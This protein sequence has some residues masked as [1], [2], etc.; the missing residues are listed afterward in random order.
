MQR[1][2]LLGILV[3]CV[4]GAPLAAF[5]QG[6]TGNWELMVA[7]PQGSNPMTMTLTQTGTAV[8]GTMT[9]PFGS[10]PMTGTVSGTDVTLAAE[11]NLQGRALPLTFKGTLQGDTFN[12]SL[13]IAGMGE[14]AFTGK[15]AAAGASGIAPTVPSAA[16]SAPASA[17]PTGAG[18]GVVSP[19]YVSIPLEIS[20]SK[21]AADVWKR[22]GK[23]CDVGEWLQVPCT[24][25]YGKD[26]ELGAI[27]SVA[28]EILVGKTD[29]SYTYTQP[30]RDGQRY[31]HYHGTLEA[32]PLT[33]TTSK[34]VYTL[35]FDNSMLADAPARDRDIA[36]KTAL[37]TRALQNMKT[38]AEGGTLPPP[39]G[40]GAVP[41]GRGAAPGG[42]GATPG[43]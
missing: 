18:I 34:L 30:A 33:A 31:N 21:P 9:S 8:T 5:A 11:L 24:I 40:R 3:A 43:Q 17:A 42:R 1:S 16:A 7:L 37:F 35:F 4:L 26:G 29:L 20:V 6:A 2:R 13:S 25:S 19:T 39:A 12:G 22:V 36:Q 10:A 14:S 28:S 23:W 38:L 15:R 32:K 27:R 41:A